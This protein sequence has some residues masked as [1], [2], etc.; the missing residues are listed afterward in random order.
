MEITLGLSTVMK[1]TA[2]HDSFP[3]LSLQLPHQLLHRL[4]LAWMYTPGCVTCETVYNIL[5]EN[6][7]HLVICSAEKL[8]SV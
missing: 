8:Y 1:I 6:V 3:R 7:A 4:F 2:L 5:Y